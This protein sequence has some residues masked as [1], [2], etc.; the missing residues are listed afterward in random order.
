MGVSIP[1]ILAQLYQ[2]SEKLARWFVKWSEVS[3]SFDPCGLGDQPDVG[4]KFARVRTLLAK[5]SSGLGFT[6]RRIK[7]PTTSDP[8]GQEEGVVF[9][10]DS[11]FFLLW[12]IP[13][14]AKMGEN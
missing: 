14:K 8:R 11:F 3:V 6:A 9:C 10:G 13:P 2:E 12:G 1:R 7:F 5:K 4:S